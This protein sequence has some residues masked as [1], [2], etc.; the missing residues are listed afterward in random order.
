LREPFKLSGI[1]PL[2]PVGNLLRAGYFNPHY[3]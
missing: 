2:L 3:S 1:N